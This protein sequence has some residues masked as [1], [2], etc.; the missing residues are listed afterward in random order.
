[1]IKLQFIERNQKIGI[2]VFFFYE[3]N[4]QNSNKLEKI[5]KCCDYIFRL[6]T[7]FRRRLLVYIDTTLPRSRT[8]RKKP[9]RVQRDPRRTHND[10]SF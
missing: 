7:R 6:A 4:Q 1:M 10:L 9:S 8:I 2:I 3:K 5:A